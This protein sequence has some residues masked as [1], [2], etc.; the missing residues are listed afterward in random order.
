MCDDDDDDDDDGNAG[1]VGG[2]RVSGLRVKKVGVLGEQ[3]M[4]Y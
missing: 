3:K 1:G 2:R 4:R